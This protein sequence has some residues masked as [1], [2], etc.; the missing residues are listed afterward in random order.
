MSH[1]T[2]VRA[3]LTCVAILAIAIVEVW[4]ALHGAEHELKDIDGSPTDRSSTPARPLV[5]P[6]FPYTAPDCPIANQYAPEIRRI[7]DAYKSNG[8]HCF[9][10]YADRSLTADSVRKHS[11]EFH[12]SHLPGYPRLGL[13]SRR[14]SRSN[15]QFGDRSLLQRRQTRVQRPSDN[16]N[17]ALGTSRQHATQHDLRDT[18]D[19]L[20]RDAAFR[21]HEPKPSDAFSRQQAQEPR[22]EFASCLDHRHLAATHVR[23]ISS[24]ISAPA[25]GS[26]NFSEHVAPIVFNRCATCHRPGEAAP[27]SL[28]SYEDVRKR[29]KLIATVTQPRYMPPWLGDSEMGSFRDD[30]RLT[31][32][33]IRT[34]QE[35]VE[36]GMPEGDPRKMTPCRSSRQDGSLASRTWSSEWRNLSRFQRTARMCSATSPFR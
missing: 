24:G 3:G 25:Q 13:Q 9:L 5:C 16:F 12:G 17:A 11:R 33:Q 35:W 34:I 15:S 20:M 26:L 32:A 28:L 21:T 8:A 6:L 29:G 4:F 30:R 10:V 31:E 7:C 23:R 18:L 14:S 2:T 36:A 19:A 27:F 22:Y 1:V